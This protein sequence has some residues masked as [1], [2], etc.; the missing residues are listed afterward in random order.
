MFWKTDIAVDLEAIRTEVRQ[1]VSWYY[2]PDGCWSLAFEKDDPEHNAAMLSNSFKLRQ[3]GGFR[4]SMYCEFHYRLRDTQIFKLY[5]RLQQDHQIGRV[6][7]LALK[8]GNCYSY[9]TDAEIRFHLAVDTNPF[10][11]FVLQNASRGEDG[12]AVV[13]PTVPDMSEYVKVLHVPADSYLYG[14]D[15]NRKHTTFN[16]GSTVRYHIVFNTVN[17]L[18]DKIYDQTS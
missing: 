15:L 3:K 7:L 11:F 4:E 17:A 14:M 9:H 2:S 18:N 16:G 10:C 8:P 1:F 5:E 12:I 13:T 6:R